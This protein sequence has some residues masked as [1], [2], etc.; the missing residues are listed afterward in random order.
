MKRVIVVNKHNGGWP[1]GICDGLLLH[2]GVCS[3]RHSMDYTVDDEFWRDVIPK[4]LRY[5]AICLRCFDKMATEQ[6][7]DISE[8]LERVQFTGIKKT[9]LL[10]PEIVYDYNHKSNDK[11]Q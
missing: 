3:I 8:H 4:N 5:G 9:I 10:K 2:C 1:E 11:M 7:Q 6:G